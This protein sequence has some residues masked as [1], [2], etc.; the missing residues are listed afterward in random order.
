MA[1]GVSGG[2]RMLAKLQERHASTLGID[3]RGR[4]RTGAAR[5]DPIFACGSAVVAADLEATQSRMIA[6]LNDRSAAAARWAVGGTYRDERVWRAAGRALPPPR[7]THHKHRGTPVVPGRQCVVLR[8]R[9]ARRKSKGHASRAADDG[10]AASSA[11][12]RLEAGSLAYKRPAEL[13]LVAPAAAPSATPNPRGTSSAT[14]NSAAARSTQ[15]ASTQLGIDS[16][17]SCRRP[18]AKDQQGKAELA[19]ASAAAKATALRPG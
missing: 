18:L 7:L 3:A 2:D 10:T 6:R 4:I 9:R 1:P 13:A 15:A 11:A 14:P 17:G 12:P 8:R 19:T 5:I 16:E